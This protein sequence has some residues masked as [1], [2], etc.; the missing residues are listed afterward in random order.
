MVE[1]KIT[2]LLPMSS[3]VSHVHVGSC[4]ARG[5]ILRALNQVVAD[6]QGDVDITTMVNL[7]YPPKTSKWY[8]VVHAGPDM[9]GTNSKYLLCGNLFK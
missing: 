7:T 8:V 3:H 9:N 1:L 2:A 5:G 6:G 4:A